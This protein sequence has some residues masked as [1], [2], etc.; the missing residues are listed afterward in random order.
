MLLFTLLVTAIISLLTGSVYYFAK[1]ERVQ[2]FEKRLKSRATYNMQLYAALGDSAFRFLRRMDTASGAGT[3]ASRSIAIL[4]DDGK[5]LYRF[6]MPEDPPLEASNELLEDTR[7]V[8]EKYFTLG[9][10]EAVAI[11]RVAAKRDFIM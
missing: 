4:K 5:V 3:D 7:H 8:G 6:D 9:N 11:H 1:L 2:V 10:L